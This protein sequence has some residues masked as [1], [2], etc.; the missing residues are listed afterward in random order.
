M[1]SRAA[2]P[3][4]EKLK[5]FDPLASVDMLQFDLQR[6]GYVLPETRQRVY[7]EELSSMAEG[8]GRAAHTEFT[9]QRQSDHLVYF[10][11]GQK[12]PY[13]SMLATG[14]EVAKREATEDTRKAFLAEWAARD[15]AIGYR[16]H[17]LQPGEQLTWHN[18]YPSEIEQRYG[19]E[20]LKRECGLFPERQMGFLYRAS[21]GPDG[22]VRL[23]SQTV[24]RSDAD[25]FRAVEGL[26]NYDA[27][28]D[29]DTMVRT[30]D[31]TLVKKYGGRFYAGRRSA[32]RNENAWAEITQHHDLIT[33]FLDG[34]ESLAAQDMPRAAL[35]RTAE[36]HVYGV[37]KA[38]KNRLESK[39]R[40]LAETQQ[41][42]YMSGAAFYH[43]HLAREVRA[44]FFEAR[45][46]GE[47]KAGCG[48]SISF[49]QEGQPK[50]GSGA[51]DAIF[52]TKLGTGDKET[53]KFDKKMYC[54]VCQAPPTEQER[55]AT[56]KKMCGPCGIC[57]GCDGKLQA[58]TKGAFALAA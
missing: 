52:G 33:Y 29:M 5:S 25:A 35:R 28:C 46:N 47:V 43:E 15:Y 53:Y 49:G 8:V 56:A 3:P 24:D 38:F 21:C 22:S 32:E 12:K 41:S 34:L 19:A 4:H 18:G 51:F 7:D 45:A 20:F 17:K 13:M 55:K 11:R 10:D 31:G 37:W 36:A 2:Q 6:H 30:Y 48:G 39:S 9:L 44:A 23:E 40:P 26:Q 16:L 54:V 1:E 14:L 42:P 50:D 58:K 27:A 57:K